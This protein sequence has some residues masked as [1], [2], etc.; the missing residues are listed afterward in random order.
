MRVCSSCGRENPDDRDFCECG[1]YL[2]WEPTGIVQ[3]VTPE[4]VQ[5]AEDAAPPGPGAPPAE[6]PPPAAPPP[7][8][9]PARVTPAAPVAPAAD[10]RYGNG[11]AAPA[12]PERT[13]VRPAVP[14][15]PSEPE[16]A[17]I[18]LRAPDGE[19]ANEGT[20]AGA[21]EPGQRERVVALVPNQSRIVDHY[22][23]RV[24]GMPDEWWSIYPDTVYLV[25]FGAGGTYEQE[26]EIHLH[27][28][29]TPEAEARLWELKVVAHSKAQGR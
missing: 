26:V 20:L 3:A 24:A 9:P 5:G 10:E 4:A 15:Q 2:R 21:V 23:L 11:H 19:P 13:A 22:M 1:E 6:P 25:P 14:A 8:P 7:Q 27:P 12:P 17:T 29:R 16:P 18:V 28:P